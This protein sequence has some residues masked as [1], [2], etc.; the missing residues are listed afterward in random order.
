MFKA[1]RGAG[2]HITFGNGWTVSVQWGCGNDCENKYA[3]WDDVNYH[4]SSSDAEVW[5]WPADGVPVPEE[6]EYSRG[7]QSPADVAAYIAAVAALPS[8]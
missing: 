2:F 3:D 7:Y 8:R 5:A 6:Y 4:K 1:T